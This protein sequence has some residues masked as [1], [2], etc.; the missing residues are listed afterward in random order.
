MIVVPI[1]IM[2]I[3]IIKKQNDHYHYLKREVVM[4]PIIAIVLQ[5]FYTNYHTINNHLNIS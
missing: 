3:V 4:I 1:T 5:T 2:I